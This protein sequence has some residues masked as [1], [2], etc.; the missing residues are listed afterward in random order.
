MHRRVAVVP[1]AGPPADPARAHGPPAGVH[2]R[3]PG[4]VGG[5]LGHEVRPLGLPDR[6]ADLVEPDDAADGPWSGAGG[7]R[8]RDRPG[9]HERDTQD[10]DEGAVPEP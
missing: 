6:V 8:R 7:R 1:A 10:R 5:G 3:E 4:R 9:R 2:D